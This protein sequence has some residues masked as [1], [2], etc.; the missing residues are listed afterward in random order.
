MTDTEE[1]KKILKQIL[2]NVKKQTKLIE[3]LKNSK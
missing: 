2:K 1:I 3:N